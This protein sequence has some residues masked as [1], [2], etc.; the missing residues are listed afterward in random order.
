MPDATVSCH[1]TKN[2]GVSHAS[3]RKRIDEPG[4]NS[5]KE[6]GVLRALPGLLLLLL[7]ALANAAQDDPRNTS[8]PPRLFPA[9]AV[10]P[11]GDCLQFGC[12]PQVVGRTVTK[13]NVGTLAL[14][15]S[16]T[17]PEVSDGSPLYV[18]GVRVQRRQHDLI[19]VT[20]S[21]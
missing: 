7:P 6:C 2:H 16:I 21:A 5:G 8:H 13:K 15:W 1:E 17:L 12:A 4:R 9:R 11:N 10:D 18:A 3:H 20:T 19:V 14:N